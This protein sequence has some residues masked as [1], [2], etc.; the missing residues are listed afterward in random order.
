[1][2]N[3]T[4]STI[5]EEY[6]NMLYRLAYATLKNQ[7]DAEDVLQDVLVLYIKK[8][9]Q[10]E[11]TDNEKAWLIRTTINVCKNKLKSAWFSKRRLG[12]F[13]VVA[14][15]E[16]HH[17]VL[18]EALLK[19]S[20]KERT[21]IHLNYYEGYTLA[22]IASLLQQNESTIRSILAR[23]RKKLKNII[24]EDFDDEKGV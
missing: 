23:S 9:P 7:S 1:M 14:T 17:E 20:N 19:L 2:M 4:C 12:D 13:E 22:E 10:F 21:I 6:G 3:K 18:G 11:N 24:K 5:F 15:M 8:Q 16:E